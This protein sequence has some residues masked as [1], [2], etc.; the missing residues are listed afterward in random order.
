MR[1]EADRNG[2]INDEEVEED[3]DKIWIRIEARK[4][5]PLE[6]WRE[7]VKEQV[8]RI[9]EQILLEGGADV[10]AIERKGGGEG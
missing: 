2:S 6:E 3:G 4:G 1:N 5:R 10:P 7:L 9:T 8:D